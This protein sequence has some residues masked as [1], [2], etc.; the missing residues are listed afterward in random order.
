[1]P[2]G[3]QAA[4]MAFSRIISVEV[5]KL[6][7]CQAFLIKFR[8]YC[9]TFLYLLRNGVFCT[10]ILYFVKL[11]TDFIKLF[12]YFTE[13]SAYQIY[14]TPNFCIDTIMFHT[15]FARKYKIVSY[16]FPENVNT[17]HINERYLH[18]DSLLISD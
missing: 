8:V 16:K 12:C 4:S 18:S 6:H 13:R 7:Y 1:M 10:T 17:A 11:Y 15:L 2:L 3:L 5:L 9:L 14:Y